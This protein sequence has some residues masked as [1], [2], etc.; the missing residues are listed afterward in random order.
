VSRDRGATSVAGSF[1]NHPLSE[2]KGAWTLPLN[3]E[4]NTENAARREGAPAP[5]REAGF[6]SEWLAFEL[7]VAIRESEKNLV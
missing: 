5:V 4:G 2:M 1:G 3:G 6:T 7:H